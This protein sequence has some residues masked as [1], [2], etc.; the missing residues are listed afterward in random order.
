MPLIQVTTRLISLDLSGGLY[1]APFPVD[2]RATD[3]VVPGNELEK[4]GVCREGKLNLKSG[5]TFHVRGLNKSPWKTFRPYRMN[6]LI[7]IDRLSFSQRTIHDS[8]AKV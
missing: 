3:W 8:Q 6:V 2:T 5:I 7:H 1:E 4:E